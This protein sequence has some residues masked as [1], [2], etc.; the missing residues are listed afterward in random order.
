ALVALCDA[1]GHD[2]KAGRGVWCADYD[3]LELPLQPLRRC[4]RESGRVPLAPADGSRWR[5][6]EID[7]EPD[8]LTVRHGE[9]TH[10]RDRAALEHGRELTERMINVHHNPSAPISFGPWS[11]RLPIGLWVQ[12]SWVSVRSFSI[13]PLP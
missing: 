13:E 1:A 6:L 9:N 3:F 11:S 7:V 10:T 8:R 2:A 12:C 4:H 5:T